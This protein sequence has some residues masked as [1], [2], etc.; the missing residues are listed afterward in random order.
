MRP[1]LGVVHFTRAAID[2]INAAYG[3][4]LAKERIEVLNFL[5]EAILRDTVR[6]GPL[7]AIVLERLAVLLTSV[8]RA[9]ACVILSSGSS[10]SPAI[11]RVADHVSV[12]VLKVESSLVSEA[13]ARFRNVGVVVT[14]RTNVHPF[15]TALEQAGRLRGKDLRVRFHVRESAFD[16]LLENAPDRHDAIVIEAIISAARD[17]V[18]AVLLP[19][20]SVARAMTRLPDLPVP[21]LSSVDASVAEVGRIVRSRARGDG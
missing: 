13:A 1:A 21:V 9:G 4:R 18:E 20:V 10:L 2:P 14:K 8:Q 17:G 12:P 7:S 15:G 16:A 11:D 19:Q 5:D 6:D 3:A